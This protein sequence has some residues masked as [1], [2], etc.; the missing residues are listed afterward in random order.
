MQAFTPNTIYSAW[1]AIGLLPY[2]P[3]A[4]LKTLTYMEPSKS[5]DK[6]ELN[7]PTTLCTLKTLRT[8][9]E[10]KSLYN[11]INELTTTRLDGLLKTLTRRCLKKLFKA[12]I[13]FATDSYI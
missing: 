5:Q 7:T 12:L 2:N 3:T 4:I 9:R 10:I 11:R 8:I 13:G 6:E 1:K